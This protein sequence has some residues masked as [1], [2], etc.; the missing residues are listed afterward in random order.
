M[1]NRHRIQSYIFQADNSSGSGLSSDARYGNRSSGRHVGQHFYRGLRAC[2]PP[3]LVPCPVCFTAKLDSR[4]KQF[5]V[6]IA[7]T[8]NC[9][10]IFPVRRKG[11]HR[12]AVTQAGGYH[13]PF[14]RR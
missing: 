5:R 11:L 3:A 2:G 8:Y 12:A 10:G 13:A 6:V 14:Q 9:Y 1:L 7:S 4:L